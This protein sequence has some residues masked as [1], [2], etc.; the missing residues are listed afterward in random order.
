M[1]LAVVEKGSSLLV[2]GDDRL[3]TGCTKSTGDSDNDSRDEESCH[4][5]ECEDPLE[6]NDLSQ[7]LADT[8]GSSKNA[9]RKTHRIILVSNEEEQSINKDAPDSN[10]GEDSGNETMGVGHN[11]TVPVYGNKGPSQRSGNDRNVDET[12]MGCMAEVQ[13]REVEEVEHEKNLS[14]DEVAT[15]EQHYKAERKKIVGY[16]VGSDRCSSVY[17]FSV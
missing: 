15:N 1:L 6:G 3:S 5:N 13:R 16:K 8:E 12:W 9:E 14:P 7:E 2:L 17:I 4:D 11:C 10:V